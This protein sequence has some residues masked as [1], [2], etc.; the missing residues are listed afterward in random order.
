MKSC[1]E[2]KTVNDLSDYS[3]LIP[4][5]QRGYRWTKQEIV[6]LLD[7]IKEF[8]PREILN[9]KD[10]TWYCLQPIVVKRLENNVV[11]VVDGQQRLTTIYLI[12]FYLNQDFVEE[13][14]DK[15]YSI[16]YQTRPK[17]KDFL[18]NPSKVDDSNIDF[19]YINKAYEAIKEWFEKN[20]KQNFDKNDYR[21]KF[22]FWT[23]IIWY[24]TFEKNLTNVFTRLNIGKISLT[25]SELIKA[26]FLNSSYYEKEEQNKIKLRQIEIS[27]E[28]DNIEN[29]FQKNKFWYFL[30]NK[31]KDDNRIEY[32][33]DLMKKLNNCDSTS[34]DHYSTFRYFY[35]KLNSETEK[36][37]NDTWEEIQQHFQRLDEW[38]ND[39]EL[40]HKIGF[41]L[42]T[43]I[44]SIET[45]YEKSD[46]SK[47]SEFKKYLDE[48]IR[49]HYKNEKI[50]DLNYSN[51]HT[52]SVLLLYNI[53]TM[54]QNERDSSRFPFD[55]FKLIKWNIEH[56]DSKKDSST[57][58]ANNR[59]IWLEEVKDYI[60]KED[61]EADSLIKKID[62]SL[63]SDNLIKKIDSSSENVS[64]VDT[65]KAFKTL[66]DSV[67]DYFDQYLKQ[68]QIDIDSISNLTL[69]DEK[70]NKS[71]KNSVFPLKRKSII[72]LD[73]S[74][75]FVPICTKNI[76]LKYF[77]DHL[78]K[79]S[80]WTDDDKKN[81]EDDLCKVLK[82]YF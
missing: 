72:D 75:S 22:K 13:R 43:E 23:K 27:S 28:W 17:S 41:I 5:Y 59:K 16:D 63:E 40:Y 49:N 24:E 12:L 45:L 34:N 50:L 74:G 21:S 67:I 70:T 26:L 58:P 80:F 65:E 15:L 10:K 57:V 32:I 61:P 55:D 60:N 46:S 29:S 2:L 71:Y 19:Y 53:I 30:S 39:R 4:S 76:F 44:K 8:E 3:F 14:R 68:H 69:L 62:S 31:N 78:T 6:D 42:T 73:K 37:I 18:L 77:S 54:L 81:Y 56:I 51:P 36:I 7:D 64:Q 52:K 79:I 38:Y 66:Y 25:N 48:C 35:N 1:I 20:N 9:S 47:K 33:F 11:E 82:H